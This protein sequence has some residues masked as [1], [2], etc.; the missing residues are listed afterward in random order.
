MAFFEGRIDEQKIS[1]QEVT[2]VEESELRVLIQ[3]FKTNLNGILGIKDLPEAPSY[4]L[5]PPP[6]HQYQPQPQ[7]YSNPHPPQQVLTH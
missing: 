2:S 5:Q 1:F 3:K 6:Q 7:F 4:Q